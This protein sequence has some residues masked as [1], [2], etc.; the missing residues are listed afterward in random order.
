MIVERRRSDGVSDQN[1]EQFQ[2][3][4]E[5]KYA[6]DERFSGTHGVPGA[7]A[8]VR[9][10]AGENSYYEIAALPDQRELRVGFMTSDRSLNETIEQ[11]ILDSGDTLEELMEVE[12]DDLGEE[13]APMIHYFERPAFCYSA[14]LSLEDPS[15]LGSTDVRRRVGHVLDA[16]Y[17]LFQEHVD[18]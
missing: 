15:Q 11:A 1:V 7:A 10:E 8:G 4:L 12:L 13:P 3:W 5:E 9:M 16:C 2:R 14:R 18:G 6:G 17:T